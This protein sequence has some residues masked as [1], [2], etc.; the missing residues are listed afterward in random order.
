MSISLWPHGLQ[1]DRFP[2][3]SPSLRVC[4][5]SRPL[6]RLCHPTVS[7]SVV[8]FSSCLQS[9][10]A[11]RSFS[12]S[13]FLPSGGQSNGTSVSAPELLM[14]IQGWFPLGLTGLI[15]LLSKGLSRV[16]SST[17]VR[18]H[19]FFGTQ[20]SLWSSSRIHTRLGKTMALTIWT[21]AGKVVSLLFNMLSS[22]V[23]AFLPRRKY[24]LISWL[25]SP[26]TV[27]SESKKISLPQFPFFPHFFTVKWW[28]RMPWSCFYKY[29]A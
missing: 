18:R 16:F 2:C 10:Q 20:P 13:Q 17:T 14:N 26:S 22:F 5:N 24:L 8:P 27:I 3:P 21:F 11:S 19:Q 9:F 28:D 1:H 15:S 25:Q 4:S 6:S 29:W 23:I 12:T 7:F